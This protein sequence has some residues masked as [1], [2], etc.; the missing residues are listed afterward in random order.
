MEL[1]FGAW[2]AASLAL[3]GC[4]DAA[5][6]NVAE[7]LFLKRVGVAY[8]PVGF[9]ASSFLLVA[10][11]YAISRLAAGRDRSRL[12]I[13]AY[14]A[15]AATLAVIS[16]IVM[17]DLP[18]SYTTLLLA[19]KQVKAVG[20]LV[21]WLTIGDLINARQTKRLAA[22]LLAGLTVG[23]IAG[24]FASGPLGSHLGL[25]TV[26]ALAS[27]ALVVSAALTV[28]MRRVRMLRL[29]SGFAAPTIRRG[30]DDGLDEAVSSVA[31]IARESR[32]FRLLAVAVICAGLLGPMLYFQ[33]SYVAD[34]ATAGT[35][36]EQ[37]LLDLYARFWG[38]TNAAVLVAQLALAGRL[39]RLVGIPTTMLV[40]PIAYLLGLAGLSMRMSLPVGLGA[41]ASTRISDH[42]VYD[43]AFPILYN[44]FPEHLRPRATALL[45]GPVKRVAGALGNVLVLGALGIGASAAFVGYVAVPIA[46][47][48]LVATVLL[49]RSYPDL[50][51]AASAQWRKHHGPTALSELLDR[52]T[53]RTMASRGDGDDVAL[54]GA[55]IDMIREAPTA[56]A[57]DALAGLATSGSDANRQ[58]AVRALA[59]IARDGP[60][61]TAYSAKAAEALAQCILTPCP[62]PDEVRVEVVQAYGK[63]AGVRG[64][65]GSEAAPV[66]AALEDPI[67][68]V[69]L[70]ALAALCGE[71]EGSA[72]ANLDRALAEAV[73]SDDALLRRTAGEELRSLM[74]V[75]APDPSWQRRLGHLGE[76]LT[77]DTTRADASR[78]I[79]ELARHHGPALA[80][81]SDAMLSLRVDA[82]PGVRGNVL[83]FIGHTGLVER[84]PCLA[85][86]LGA[87]S[88][89]E[90]A[91]ARGGLLALGAAAI[92]PLLA[93]YWFGRRKARNAILEVVGE[94][95]VERTRLL[96]IY[97]R[98]LET[99]Q[100]NTVNL[101]ALTSGKAPEV[102]L[103]RLGERVDEGIHSLL[104]LTATIKN[105]PRVAELARLL[106]RTRS[107]NEH[108][109][110][111]EALDTLLGV[112]EKAQLVPLLEVQSLSARAGAAASASGIAVPSFEDA[113]RQAQNDSDQ[114]TRVLAKATSLGDRIDGAEGSSPIH[115]EDTQAM[116][117]QVDIALK[118]KT[119]PLFARLTARQLM[120]LAEFAQEEEWPAEH[121]LFHIGDLGDCMYLIVDGRV[122]VRS[123]E[124]T[125]ATL[126]N[127]DFFG[128]LT[129]FDDQRRSATIVTRS[130]VRLL[131]L[132]RADVL[133]LMEDIPGVA[134][135]VCRSLARRLRDANIRH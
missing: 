41:V 29:E 123:G 49:W 19:S 74:L 84:A 127:K 1:R 89:V 124:E 85:E 54:R 17:L 68:A 9:L 55:A 125:L 75:A 79:A 57:V 53:V 33:F 112:D 134:I 96:E 7:T 91:G 110:L 39:Y 30:G 62:F 58:V 69:R 73:Q 102:L 77:S 105:T 121:P 11:T 32:L 60:D 72:Q 35:D 13:T 133:A 128:E 93:Q 48:W 59:R 8:L 119:I 130:A 28:P 12:L 6:Q 56:V 50:L 40:T 109:I 87:E 80:P 131:R 31:D 103:Q 111:V 51:L 24:S 61:E 118:L 92:E 115:T 4:T 129:L 126:G 88:E 46:A 34:L 42:A 66:E 18:G 26:V 78:A 122:D 64:P 63:L 98:E 22:P 99:V 27:A 45:A 97:D 14:A 67:P 104:L 71:S 76:L 21:F 101:H 70:A 23:S 90:A 132:G 95:D 37:R 43:P 10:T 16:L 82:D 3:L 116:L 108:A 117:D 100:R 120:D 20:L 65:D 113:V 44:L 52:S 2:A 107:D 135:E 83:S 81:V 106:R 5:L 38:W 47:V 94:L 25:D 36:G 15:L 86:S 114:L